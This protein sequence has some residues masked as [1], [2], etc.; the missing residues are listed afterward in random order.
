MENNIK[1]FL[2]EN[3]K[4]WRNIYDENHSDRELLNFMKQVNRKAINKIE[5]ENKLID[6]P[7]VKY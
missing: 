6:F 5:I 1:V 7:I 2:R 3:L 4:N